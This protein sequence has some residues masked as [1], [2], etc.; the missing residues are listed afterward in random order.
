MF[1][2]YNELFNS[3]R[4]ITL[5]QKWII[6]SAIII[7]VFGAIPLMILSPA[8][9]ADWPNHLARVSIMSNVLN[10]NAFW[11]ARYSFQGLLIPNAVL[12]AAVLSLMRLGFS[13][14]LAGSIFLLLCYAVFVIGFVRLSNLSRVPVT[15][16]TS[17]GSMAFYTGLTVYGLVNFITG[18]GLAMLA[19]SFWMRDD[20]SIARRFLIVVLATPFILF[21]HVVAALV[22]AGLCGCYDLVRPV[23]SMDRRA[24]EVFPAATAFVIGVIGYKLSAASSDTMSVT[25]DG[26]PGI[27][28]IVIGKGRQIAQALTSGDRL[29][30]ALFVC[31]IV[32]LGTLLWQRRNEVRFKFAAPVIAL[33]M[34]A[35]LAPNGIG[36]GLL[37]DTRLFAWTLFL[38]LALLPWSSRLSTRVEVIL[39]A[40][41]LVRTLVLIVTWTSYAPAYAELRTAFA[42]LP[43]GST[44]LDAYDDTPS[45]YAYRR[46]PI[47][48]SA[49]LAVSDGIYVPSV[50]AEPTQQPLAVRLEWRPL[51]LW[52]H[53]A[54]ARTPDNLRSVRERA[55]RFC[56]LDPNTHLLLMHVTEQPPFSIEEPCK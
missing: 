53:S 22:F 19:A 54:N 34:V 43:K 4:N 7:A 50:F 36:I 29:A 14:S 37:L 38:A 32:V 6:V 52:S 39:I 25:Y 47:W 48:N 8:P 44:L 1:K 49:S 26:A 24:I 35:T 21:C 10:G 23:R 45:F 15:I 17:L 20:A 18:V 5:N 31:V 33:A 55:R 40:V 51:W 12:D 11:S 3:G 28:S 13:T 42:M 16:A 2:I 46:P 56:D 9:L 30:D 41:F 27:K